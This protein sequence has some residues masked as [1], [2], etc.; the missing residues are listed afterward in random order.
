MRQL[1][2]EKLLVLA[3]RVYEDP[4]EKE[5]ILYMNTKA[6]EKFYNEI[7]KSINDMGCINNVSKTGIDEDI[8]K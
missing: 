5:G 6:R 2:L 8:C 1:T 3:R 7:N 4:F